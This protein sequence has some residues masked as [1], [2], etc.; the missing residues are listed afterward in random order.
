[1]YSKIRNPERAAAGAIHIPKPK[2]YHLTT[3]GR[4]A[5]WTPFNVFVRHA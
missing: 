1:M 2:V 4:P 3:R 5:H